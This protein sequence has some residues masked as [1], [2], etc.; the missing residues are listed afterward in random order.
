MKIDRILPISI[1]AVL[2]VFFYILILK[3]SVNIPNGDDMYCLMLFAQDF[4]DAASWGERLHLLLQQW[5]EHRILYSRLTALVSYVIHGQQVNFVTIILIGNLTLVAFTALFWKMIKQNGV[6]MYYLLPVILTLFSPV[7]YEANL[8]AGACTV[9]MPVCF[10]GLLTVYLLTLNSQWAFPAAIAIALLATF[11]FGNGMF[12]FVAGLFVLI[13]AKKYR[14]AMIWVPIMIAGIFFYFQDYYV[15]SATNAF[16]VSAHFQ[17]P[18]YLFYNF[19]GF[20][21]GSLDYT[22]SSNAPVHRDNFLGIAFGIVLTATILAGIYYTFLDIFIRPSAKSRRFQIIWFGMVV[23]IG[24]T[25]LSMAYSRTTGQSINTLSSRYKIFSMVSFI[26]GYI[27]CLAFFRKKTLVGLAFGVS[28]AVILIFNYYTAYGKLEN[29]KSF[30]LAGL[31]NY[32]TNHHWVIYRHTAFY[33][34]ASQAVSDTIRNRPHPVFEFR[35]NFP[36]L[37]HNALR[38][39]PTLSGSHIT[40]QKNCGGFSGNCMTI[41]NETFPKA[42]NYNLG[43]YLVVYNDKNIFLFP[44]LPIKNGRSNM[45]KRGEYF[46]DGFYFEENFGKSLE[47]DAEYKLAVFCPS[48]KEKIRLL[49]E[50]IKG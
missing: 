9:Y 21:G 8:W 23:F 3:N 18:A 48:G 26:L 35:N 44:A 31:Y 36:A 15:A 40:Q 27:W 5:V 1:C 33:E 11:S 20:V 50:R 19:F 39:A 2:I 22:D 28:S 32:T 24:V 6:S 17:H 37:T 4:Q 47:K 43:I 13:V 42:S 29:F 46:K 12:S 41:S 7:M 16:S 10:M 49:N 38:I 30:Q 45:I 14:A 25:A 34:Q